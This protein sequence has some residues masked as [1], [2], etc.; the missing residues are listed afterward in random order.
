MSHELGDYIK[1]IQCICKKKDTL[2]YT[3]RYQGKHILECHH[4]FKRF[5]I[6]D[7]ETKSIINV[8]DE[9]KERIKATLKAKE[10]KG[11]SKKSE[12]MEDDFDAE[13]EAS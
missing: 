1:D 11:K 7:L 10:K 8:L 13:D 6:D 3:G 9:E 4:C 2:M 12:D 5:T